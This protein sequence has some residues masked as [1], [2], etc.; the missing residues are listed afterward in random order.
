MRF[1]IVLKIWELTSGIRRKSGGRRTMEKQCAENWYH[2]ENRIQKGMHEKRYL[3]S[4]ANGCG[5]RKSMRIHSVGHGTVT[6]SEKCGDTWPALQERNRHYR[7]PCSSTST[8]LRSSTN[9]HGSHVLLGASRTGQWDD[10]KREKLG[11]DRYGKQHRGQKVSGPAGA[12]LCD[13]KDLGIAVPS[14][15]VLRFGHRVISMNDACPEDSTKDAGEVCK[16]RVPCALAKCPRIVFLTACIS[17]SL[18]FV[19]LPGIDD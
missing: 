1:Q 17:L 5:A 7:S 13:N 16:R 4:L 15:Q 6:E 12:I 18:T 8:T 11:Q 10:D 2:Q 3:E 19:V 9:W 14:W